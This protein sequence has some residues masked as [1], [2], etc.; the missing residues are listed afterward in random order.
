[1][2][3][4]PPEPDTD[5]DPERRPAGADV[6][7]VRDEDGV[8]VLTMTRP[9][10]RNAMDT[11]LLAALLDALGAAVADDAVGALVLTGA[12]G[13]FSAGADL[14]EPL[15]HGGQVRRMELFCEV[16]EALATCPTA[17][18][19]ALA[20]PAVGGGA[21]VAVACD[22]RVADPTALLRFPGLA[23]RIPVGPAKLVGLVGMG[24]AKD[25]I[26]TGR[27]VDADEAHR[28]GIV[29]R[30]APHGGALPL[31]L[32][33]ARAL[34]AADRD[35]LRYLKR[36][37]DAFGGLSDRVGAENDALHALAEAG[38]DYRALTMAKPGVGGWSTGAWARR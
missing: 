23:M 33:V 17:T 27:T 11:A 31:A 25:L 22:L 4:I 20:G 15:D 34:A 9:A 24:T 10:A 28:L 16:Y 36:Q 18:V 32:E 38:G 3:P 26:L 2:T 13:A 6:I 1:M 14:R 7:D 35:T 12:P 30:L 29:Q 19:A 5:S 37:L 21:E 8:R